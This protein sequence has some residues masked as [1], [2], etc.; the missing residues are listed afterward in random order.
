VFKARAAN[1]HT[2][3]EQN[4]KFVQQNNPAIVFSMLCCS[5]AAAAFPGQLV[6]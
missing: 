6:V 3:T 4:H 1:D 5:P 2:S